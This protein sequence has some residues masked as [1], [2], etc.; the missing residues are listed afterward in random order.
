[1]H[2]NGVKLKQRH[3]AMPQKNNFKTFYAISFAWQLGFFIV[4]PIG[5]FLL[6]GFWGD[7]VFQTSP[8][9]LVISIILGL[10]ITIYEIY[11]L[12]APLIKNNH[13]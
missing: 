2:N 11:H 12:L 10:A 13:D 8:L 9:L 4:V 3:K 7:K 1:M 5:G 6:L